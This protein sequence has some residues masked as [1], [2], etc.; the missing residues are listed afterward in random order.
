M[1][2]E[3]GNILVDE[4]PLQG[5]PARF[6]RCCHQGWAED[7]GVGEG[8]VS[9]QGGAVVVLWWLYH[10]FLSL[11]IIP[12]KT[13]AHRGFPTCWPSQGAGVLD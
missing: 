1:I 2:G 10:R 9:V 13:Q 5:V 11:I 3:P 12:M 8:Y 6:L 7:R 4:V